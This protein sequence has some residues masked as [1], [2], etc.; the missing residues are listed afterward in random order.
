MKD[1][2][3]RRYPLPIELEAPM[4]RYLTEH[5]SIL[6]GG[7]K[8]DAL[9]ISRRGTPISQDTFTG[10]LAQLTR[11]HF[12]LTLR[13]HAFRHIA[14]TSIAEVDPCHVGMICDIL[15]H[16]TLNMAER[17]YNRA[18]AVTASSRMQSLV[19]E[20]RRE[21]RKTERRSRWRLPP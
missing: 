2:R 20:I 12:G 21:A 18:S 13:P 14:A 15:G 10:C 4:R 11:R 1:K 5:R 7:A 6:L 8:T 17:H 16:A 19:Q 9:W 3:A